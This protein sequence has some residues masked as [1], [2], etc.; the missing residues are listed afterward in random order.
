MMS[1]A[2]Q[3]AAHAAGGAAVEKI[4]GRAVPEPVD[5][6]AAATDKSTHGTDRLTQR[7][8][9]DRDRFFDVEQFGRSPSVT[10]E[11][12]RRMRL[13][14]QDLRVVPACQGTQVRAAAPARRP[15]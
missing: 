15:C 6:R 7:A 5:Q 11:D 8:D 13:V 12:A 10:A 14:D 1:K 9:A 3:A 4:C 2:A